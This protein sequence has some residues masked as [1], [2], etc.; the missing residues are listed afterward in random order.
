MMLICLNPQ[1]SEGCGRL[2]PDNVKHCSECGRSLRHAMRL[3]D[4][5]IDGRYTVLRGIGCGGFG[6]VYQAEVIQRPG[7]LVAVKETFNPDTIRA[8]QREFQVLKHHQQSNLVRY[9]EM[10]EAN[11]N[12]YLVMEFVPGK[13]L[14]EILNETGQSLAESQ[15]LA[16]AVQLCQVLAY[17]HRQT[18]PILH[19]D[20][21][22][23]NIRLRPDGLIKL[24]DF[25]LV[26]EGLQTSI[27][28]RNGL[29]PAYA[30]PEQ[31][32]KST[33]PR[34]DIYSLGATLYQLLTATIPLPATDRLVQTP[35]RLL[36]PNHH[37]PAI[38]SYVADAIMTAMNL[39]SEERFAN[40]ESFQQALMGYHVAE[41]VR[42]PSTAPAPLPVPTPA[43]SVVS[44]PQTTPQT[45][46]NQ[47]WMSLLIIPVVLVALIVLWWWQRLDSPHLISLET[48][49]Q[50][51]ELHVMERHT[52]QIVSVAFAPDSQTVASAALDGTVKLWDT[53]T[54]AL[55]S[56]PAGHTDWVRDVAWSP[57]DQ[58]L[59]S[60]SRDKT[61]R[62]WTVEDGVLQLTFQHH[63]EEVWSVA[64]H[65]D[66]E[67]L[68]SAACASRDD[69][70]CH[71]GEI[72]LWRKDGTVLHQL[73]DME[74][75]TVGGVSVAFA[76]DGQTLAVA[77][78]DMPVRLWNVSDGTLQQRLTGH[79]DFVWDVAW[80][81]DGQTLAS[82]SRDETVRLW[83][84][85][86]GSLQNTLRGHTDFV[87]G[88]AWHPDGEILASASKDQTIRLWDA[89]D[90]KV[91]RTL[92]GHTDGVVS[93]AFTPDGQ[94]LASTARDETVRLW[95]IP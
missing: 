6:M 57:D 60:A 33:S 62:L 18:P 46:R 86:D 37:N 72:L 92:E 83:N 88:V 91:L 45:N 94:R 20:I 58:I 93:L 22:P 4:Q 89:D 21:K 56:T 59:A 42:I 34:S 24:V 69:D 49:D 9:E 82:V 25:G 74:T 51:A 38:K 52:D 80:S 61:V 2:N 11:G 76:P 66:G 78:K 1:T 28:T 79:T 50:V 85:Q 48:A 64:W 23:A 77:S 35:D 27:H 54:G 40:V 15:V 95:G 71:A 55:L 47:L 36:P 63:S 31:Y 7:T 13:N 70:N 29:T 30:P 67:I 10:F 84:A 26:K 44:S 39:K 53:D 19:R 73:R 3:I 8:F 90:G 5:V 75:E 32:R 68:A 87:W 43:P 81:P 65:P 14:Y 12:G 41:T 17:L 16:Y